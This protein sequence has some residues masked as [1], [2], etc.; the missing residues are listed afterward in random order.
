MI[1]T[2]RIATVAALALVMG[3]AGSNASAQMMHYDLTV[4]ISLNG[5]SPLHQ[6][7]VCVTGEVEPICQDIKP[8]TQV[9]TDYT[10][11]GLAGG[12][13]DVTVSGVDPYLDAVAHVDLT[14][15][16]TVVGIELE[17]EDTAQPAPELPNTGSGPMSAVSTS[18]TDGVAIMAAFALVMA[19]LSSAVVLRRT[20]R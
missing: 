15:T 19:A 7:Q 14:E 16:S 11:T 12:E 8:G 18:S 4:Q 5:S 2:L 3:L 13:H 6:G 1:Q 10:F 17:M 20:G 9:G